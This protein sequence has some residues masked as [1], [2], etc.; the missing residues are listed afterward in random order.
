MQP[1][2]SSFAALESRSKDTRTM[3]IADADFCIESPLALPEDE[4][5]LWRVDLDTV[6]YTISAEIVQGRT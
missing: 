6:G 2:D 1:S 3:N 5:Q 4:V